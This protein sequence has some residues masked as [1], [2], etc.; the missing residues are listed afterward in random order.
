MPS[1][2]CKRHAG[3]GRGPAPRFPPPPQSLLR[4]FKQSQDVCERIIG[5]IY[6]HKTLKSLKDLCH[7]ED[8]K[9]VEVQI[10]KQLL[11]VIKN[12]TCL[13]A[14]KSIN[15]LCRLEEDAA[16]YKIVRAQILNQYALI[17]CVIY[18][19]RVEYSESNVGAFFD[20]MHMVRKYHGLKDRERADRL[21]CVECDDPS[22]DES[23]LAGRI[24]LSQHVTAED[25]K[26]VSSK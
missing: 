1:S 24:H 26:R 21:G 6:C 14:L 8:Y 20:F 11:R 3:P 18:K 19:K 12:T 16:T 22:I 17:K 7:N 25:I 10:N 13:A 23:Q 15:D 5:N 9:F 2:S 4:L